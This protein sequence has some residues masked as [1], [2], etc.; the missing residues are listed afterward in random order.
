[1]R[2]GGARPLRAP[3]PPPPRARPSLTA[4]P[5]T[6]LRRGDPRPSPRGLGP[7]VRG[8]AAPPAPAGPEAAPP[9]PFR[10]SESLS[11]ETEC[12][13]GGRNPPLPPLVLSLLLRG[14]NN[15]RKEAARRGA[16]PA[17]RPGEP[18]EPRQPP[19]LPP[20]L[21]RA[22]T[23]ALAL[24]GRQPGPEQ[25][26][27]G[28]AAAMP[29][30]RPRRFWARAGAGR[31]SRARPGALT[32]PPASPARAGE[33]ATPSPG[34][35][36][37]P[38]PPLPPPGCSPG[39]HEQR[40]APGGPS[41]QG[42]RLAGPER[43]PSARPCAWAARGLPLGARGPPSRRPPCRPFRSRPLLTGLRCEACRGRLGPQQP[44]VSISAVLP[45][46]RRVVSRAAL[47]GPTWSARFRAPPRQHHFPRSPLATVIG[48]R[49]S[50]GGETPGGGGGRLGSGG[51][52][53][54]RPT[55]PPP[56]FF[57]NSTALDSTPALRVPVRLSYS[58]VPPAE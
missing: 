27:V 3:T 51:I 54:R 57:F 36:A 55:R 17:L 40:R 23:R 22:R 34:Q 46:S 39:G 6:R 19:S 24:S 33:A 53:V 38:P 32:E 52:I 37:P 2:G 49:P 25:L 21:G 56:Q 29:A 30:L 48:S 7:S 50:Q 28:G 14:S 42:A 31:L 47:L 13:W 26:L 4:A 20:S 43:Q 45:A 18:P 1:M 12:A 10:A 35:A 15:R 11:A 8:A 5:P 58:R 41:L 44:L 16:S 9:P